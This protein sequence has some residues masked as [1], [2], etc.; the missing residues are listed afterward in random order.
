[1]AGDLDHAS[2]QAWLMGQRI[3]KEREIETGQGSAGK[4]P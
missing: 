2:H 1:M 4:T 3:N